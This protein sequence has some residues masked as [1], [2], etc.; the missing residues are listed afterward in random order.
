MWPFNRP[1]KEPKPLYPEC[2]WT[3]E[4]DEFRFRGH[5]HTGTEMAISFKDLARVA[6]ET[7]D[8]GPWGADVIWLLFDREGKP[9]LVFPQGATGEK[10][11]VDRLM[12]LPNFDA[13][14]MIKAM[15]STSNALFVVWE[16]PADQA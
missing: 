6:I 11:T 5:D 4:F 13:D 10:A 2:L 3:V 1:K 16:K 8:S 7:N 14:Q 15:G 9:G 12:A